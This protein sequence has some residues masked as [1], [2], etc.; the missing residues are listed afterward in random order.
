MT[1]VSK[2][3]GGTKIVSFRLPI[4]GYVQARE[5]VQILLDK[6]AIEMQDNST[7]A[8]KKRQVNAMTV[9]KR[10]AFKQ[11]KTIAIQGVT[12]ECGCCIDNELFRR[13]IGCRIARVD[14]R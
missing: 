11:S 8:K 6:I 13:A 1:R 12:Y 10:K 7:P 9:M 14:H 2:Y 5:R 4:D 3:A